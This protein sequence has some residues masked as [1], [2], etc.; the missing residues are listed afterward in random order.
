MNTSEGLIPK[1]DKWLNMIDA[2]DF[3]LVA[4]SLNYEPPSTLKTITR[5][6]GLLCYAQ[7]L[8]IIKNHIT[9]KQLPYEQRRCSSTDK[10]ENY[11]QLNAFVKWA[12]DVMAWDLPP[13]LLT[14]YNAP[15]PA[16]SSQK[17]IEENELLRQQLSDA[18]AKIDVLKKQLNE[19]Q[20]KPIAIKTENKV[21]PLIYHLCCQLLNNGKP[22]E[23]P[24]QK[25]LSFITDDLKN[26]RGIELGSKALDDYYKLGEKIINEKN[27]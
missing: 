27:R 12:V 20:E 18:Q 2:T 24:V 9:N 11:V 25:T 17:L 4:L 15:A 21:M 7:R 19:Y 14:V 8:S 26:K 6:Q 23:R 10:F 22:V 16:A 3:Q 5:F 1:W 13:E